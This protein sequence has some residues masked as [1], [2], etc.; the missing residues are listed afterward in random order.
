MFLWSVSQHT[1]KCSANPPKRGAGG[2][3]AS[4]WYMFGSLSWL[5]AALL[6]GCRTI[7]CNQWARKATSEQWT[8]REG[9]RMA[10]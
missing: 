7:D 5:A 3:L 8:G 10:A 6:S 9:F 4:P 1:S 2:F